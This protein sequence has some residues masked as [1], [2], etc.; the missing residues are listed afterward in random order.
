MVGNLT[1]PWAVACFCLGSG[2]WDQAGDT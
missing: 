1:L 2:E